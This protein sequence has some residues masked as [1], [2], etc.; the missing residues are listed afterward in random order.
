MRHDGCSTPVE[1]MNTHCAG[2]PVIKMRLAY[3]SPKWLP[4]YSQSGQL[5]FWWHA[6]LRIEGAAVF[7]ATNTIHCPVDC[8]VST[9]DART[10]RA[11]S[12]AWT[13]QRRAVCGKRGQGLQPAPLHLRPIRVTCERCMASI[14]DCVVCAGAAGMPLSSRVH[15]CR[16]PHI[17]LHHLH[18]K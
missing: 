9:L 11:N 17:P 3:C 18:F 14:T 2:G 7:R 15:K 12:A 6:D 13:E 8:P 1:Q 4:A 5:F 10:D 16:L